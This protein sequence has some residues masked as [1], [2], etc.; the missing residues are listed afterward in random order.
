MGQTAPHRKKQRLRSRL[1]LDKANGVLSNN[2]NHAFFHGLPCVF[3][4]VIWLALPQAAK[5]LSR[6]VAC[7]PWSRRRLVCRQGTEYRA[8]VPMSDTA[9]VRMV[10]RGFP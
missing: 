8:G 5:V 1:G 6:H 7:V 2:P 10:R 4:N 3:L 9:S